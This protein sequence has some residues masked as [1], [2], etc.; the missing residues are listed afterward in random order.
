ME[1]RN[2]VGCSLFPQHIIKRGRR[3]SA[4]YTWMKTNLRKGNITSA[5]KM[6][7]EMTGNSFWVIIHWQ[8]RKENSLQKQVL[9]EDGREKGICKEQKGELSNERRLNQPYLLEKPKT[10][11]DLSEKMRFQVSNGAH[12]LAVLIRDGWRN[13]VQEGC[14]QDITEIWQT[15]SSPLS[16]ES[17]TGFTRHIFLRWS[18]WNYYGHCWNH[19]YNNK[20]WLTLTQERGQYKVLGVWMVGRQ[21]GMNGFLKN[22]SNPWRQ[23]SDMNERCLFW[24]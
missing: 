20:T 4:A 15:I 2:F 8:A 3:R 12:T 21:S 16:Y 13:L 6:Q 22:G 11:Q 9:W 18:N 5:W 19:P 7:L 17:E 10:H 14:Y 24:N 1:P 23:K